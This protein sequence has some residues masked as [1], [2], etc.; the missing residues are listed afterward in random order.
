MS[1]MDFLKG[2]VDCFSYFSFI[3]FSNQYHPCYLQVYQILHL[4]QYYERFLQSNVYLKLMEELGLVKEERLEDGDNISIDDGMFIYRLI[5]NI[6]N[7]YNI[8]VAPLL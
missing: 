7:T 4:E 6:Y 2:G 5:S 8:T 1:K 3:F